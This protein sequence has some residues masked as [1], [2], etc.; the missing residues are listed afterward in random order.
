MIDLFSVRELLRS[1]MSPGGTHW[2]EC[3]RVHVDC[4]AWRLLEVVDRLEWEHDELLADN[5]Q[6]LAEV[7]QLR[8]G[9]AEWR[10]KAEGFRQSWDSLAGEM[11]EVEA[12]RDCLADGIR[13]LV[14]TYDPYEAPDASMPVRELRSLLDVAGDDALDEIVRI[15]EDA[16]LYND[17]AE[18]DIGRPLYSSL[19]GSEGGEDGQ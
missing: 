3:W 10:K 14:N 12:E 17:E 9:R 7:E 1:R 8:R 18:D 16:G 6:L 11:A 2:G 5:E 19:D 15:S 13:F 4:A